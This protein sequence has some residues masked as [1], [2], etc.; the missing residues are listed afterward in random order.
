[1]NQ[2]FNLE[3]NSNT[4]LTTFVAEKMV[5]CYLIICS[6]KMQITINYNTLYNYVWIQNNQYGILDNTSSEFAKTGERAFFNNKNL[7]GK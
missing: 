2:S 1:M 4:L 6:Q 3:L 5:S 7:V